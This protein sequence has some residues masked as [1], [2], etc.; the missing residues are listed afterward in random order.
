M[1]NNKLTVG[2]AALVAII[3]TAGMAASTF[4]YQGDP[5]VQGPNV[6]TATHEAMT[7]AFESGSYEAWKAN[8]PNE[9][10][11]RMMEVI[12]DEAS[13][14]KFAE[15]RELRLA[16]DTEGADALR[17][18]LGLGLHDGESRGTGMKNSGNKGAG[19]GEGER[20]AN[21]SRGSNNENRGQNQGGNFVDA[22]GDGAC[23]L[24]E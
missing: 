4:A 23:D 12:N 11:G 24:I 16:G 17:V 10:K 5:S 13:F 18:E 22:N 14:A 7:A 21:G 19:Q 6:D 15:I 3:A 1:K 9:S 8:K 20:G 2:A